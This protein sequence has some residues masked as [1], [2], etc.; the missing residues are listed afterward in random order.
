MSKREVLLRGADFSLLPRTGQLIVGFSGGADSSALAHALRGTVNPQ[1]LLL[2]H[3]NHLLRG[4]EAEADEAAVRE[5]SRQFGL[6]LVVCRRDVAALA[7][8]RGIGLEECGRQERYL[9]F[10]SLATGEDDRILTAHNA[11]DNAET[12]LLHLARGTA[13][14]GLCGIPERRGNILRPLLGVTRQE[15]EDYCMENGISYVTDSTNFSDAYARNRLRHAVLPVLR[16]LNPRFA[17]SVLET[18][19]S[20]TIDRDF[21][22]AQAADLLQKSRRPGGLETGILKQADPALQVR[23]L[24]FFL[25]ELHCDKPEKKHLTAALGL[26]DGPGTLCLPGGIRLSSS[27]G[28][29]YGGPWRGEQSLPWAC[30]IPVLEG[31]FELPCGKILVLEKKQWQTGENNLKINKLLFKNFLDYDTISGVLLARSRKPGD[32]FSLADRQGS[33]GL[34]QLFQEQKVP[35]PFRQSVVLLECA[36][37]LVFCEGVGAA[38]AFRVTEKTV[39]A[40]CVRIVEDSGKTYG[41]REGKGGHYL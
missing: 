20:L 39:T 31:E 36:G 4:A 26:L 7:K 9:F 18:S 19:R 12:V 33:R 1:R 28:L 6:R 10:S 17:L 13:L 41:S 8:Q 2:A 16:E 30:E 11:E 5:F 32:R 35:V 29:L 25:E 34:K 14:S 21:L 38:K 40:L 15:I 3:V 37:E 23:T 22:R 24:Q 27:Q